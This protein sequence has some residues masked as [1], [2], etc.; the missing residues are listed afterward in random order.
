MDHER[1]LQRKLRN[2]LQSALLIASMVLLCGYLAWVIGGWLVAWAVSLFVVVSY[3]LNPVASPGLIMSMYR[4]RP[5]RPEAAPRLYALLREL[6]AR[7]G[8]ERMPRLY[9][10]PTRLLNAFTSG[11]RSDAA[12]AVSD[13]LLRR[14]DL[15]ELAGVLAHEVSHVAS[16]DTRVMALADL[17]SRVTGV[18]SL[19]GQVLLLINL[20]LVMFSEYA[21][22]WIPIIVMLAAPSLSA[23]V[24]LALSRS[25][26]YEADRSAAALTGDPEGLAAA[27]QKL[28]YMQGH[29]WERVFLPGQRIPDRSLLRTHPPTEERIQRL[30]ELRRLEGWYS[31]RRLPGGGRSG[32][33]LRPVLAVPPM[34]PRWHLSGFWF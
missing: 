16:G 6:A 14:L 27:L 20:P 30:L 10:V 33:A 9:Y 31:R 1:L 32:D 13:G 12:I 21:L 15:R 4:G 24:Q 19:V 7:A 8:L 2:N 28:E 18:L 5:I 25:R 29:W 22:N 11:G 34:R 17:T 23:L 26:E 3:V